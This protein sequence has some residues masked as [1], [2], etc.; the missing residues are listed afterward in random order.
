MGTGKNL[1][2]LFKSNNTT[3]LYVNLTSSEKVNVG[4]FFETGIT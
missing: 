1:P 3:F 4:V 2:L